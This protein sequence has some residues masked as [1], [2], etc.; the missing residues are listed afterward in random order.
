MLGK[1]AIE[2]IRVLCLFQ[3][4]QMVWRDRLYLVL[5]DTL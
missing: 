5:E 4:I 2:R 1:E 3:I